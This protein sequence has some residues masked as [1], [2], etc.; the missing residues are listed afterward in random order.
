MGSVEIVEDDKTYDP[1]HDVWIDASGCMF[2]K[3]MFDPSAP[4]WIG[5]SGYRWSVT[6]DKEY[7]IDWDDLSLPN[8]LKE[9]FKR[10]L[11][12]K[13]HQNAPKFLDGSRHA[14]VNLSQ[15]LKPDEKSFS[16]LSI[17]ALVRLWSEMNPYYAS[18]LREAYSWLLG[19]GEKG[20]TASVAA[21]LKGM[22]V[23]NDVRLHRD[24]LNW[25]PTKGALTKE[26]ETLLR[27]AIESSRNEGAREL[28][29]RLYCWLL[30]ATLKRGKQVREMRPDCLKVVEKNGVK[31]Y[32]VLMK[33]V[34]AQTG[35][36]ERWW[37]ISEA[38][39]LEMLRYSADPSVRE[40][41]QRHNRFWVLDCPGLQR[42]GVVGA[43]HGKEVLRYYVANTL[44]LVSPRTG[45]PLHVTPNR[46][47]HTGATR[48]AY[49]GVPRDIIA[50][51][52]E[53]DNPDSCQSYIDAVGSEL[54]PAID[55]ADRNM[56]SLFM[57]LNHVYFKGKVV[58][59][60][61]D[62]P[63]MI[64][65]FSEPTP[66]FVG[67]CGRDTC[68]EG[69]CQKHPFVG[70]YNGCQSFLAW[71]EADHHRALAYADKELERWREA[72][73]HVE[74][75]ATIKEYEELRVN[76]LAV[77]DW[78]AQAKGGSNECSS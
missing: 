29:I 6:V 3:N 47:R 59:D 12:A 39:Y 60:L 30:I 32:F 40:L 49:S 70:C 21:K 19:Q 17:V 54:C 58:E 2:V 78:I 27:S 45:L 22:K 69:R 34:K 26:E 52:L 68:K 51:I 25:H 65:T 72:S 73:G 67:S 44:G 74:Q 23:R 18:W 48:L 76:I 35:D 71:R 36:P 10:Y 53:H 24:V 37:P 42:Y 4:E 46:I 20:V 7:W 55:R 1:D 66:L 31:E 57:Q 13:L 50:E 38:L 28:G 11:R 9:P 61:T 43:A 62:Q 64:P 56:G 33:P 75:S 41:Q 16:D 77:I 14:L 63:I 15:F 8:A 5:V